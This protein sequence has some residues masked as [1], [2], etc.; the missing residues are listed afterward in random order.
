M[1]FKTQIYKKT[2]TKYKMLIKIPMPGKKP[3]IRHM[4][5]PNIFFV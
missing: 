1:D 3:P 2:S 5:R 4:A